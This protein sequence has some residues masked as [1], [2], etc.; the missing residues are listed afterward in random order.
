MKSM[1]EE[2]YFAGSPVGNFM[3][4]YYKG[5]GSPL[6]IPMGLAIARRIYLLLGLT[7]CLFLSA[8]LAILI[9]LGHN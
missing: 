8:S 2:A 3:E 7:W 1:L 5:S 6:K 4:I 9:G